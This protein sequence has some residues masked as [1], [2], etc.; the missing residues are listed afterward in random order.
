ML[1]YFNNLKVKRWKD[2]QWLIIETEKLD[3]CL[4]FVQSPKF[5]NFEGIIV[6]RDL[7]YTSQDLSFLSKIPFIQSLGISDHIKDI[8][9]I[10]SLHDLKIL[11]LAD[12]DEFI[13]LSRFSTLCELSF[14]WNLK[15]LNLGQCKN[16]KKLTL[17]GFSPKTQ[18]IAELPSLPCLK[19]IS[20]VKSNVPNLS[21]M[22]KFSGLE[23]VELHG[24]SRLACIDGFEFQKIKNLVFSDCRQIKNHEAVKKLKNLEVLKFN[25]CG[26]MRSIKFIADLPRLK[27]FIFVDTIIED[28]DVEPC[29]NLE[30]VGFSNAK[31]YSHT[32]EEIKNAIAKR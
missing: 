29:L 28:G 16:L 30:L 22:E 31:N 8:S 17:A 10:Y 19:E 27:T 25:N 18:S 1:T 11:N 32:L 5:L 21:A 12:N 7:G 14:D 13:D 2:R 15:I 6:S 9:G 23:S 20:I 26:S 3:D 4:R 24:F